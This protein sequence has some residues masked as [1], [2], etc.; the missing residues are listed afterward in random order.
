MQS[1]H[2][3]SLTDGSLKALANEIPEMKHVHFQYKEYINGT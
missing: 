3:S 1:L 2:I